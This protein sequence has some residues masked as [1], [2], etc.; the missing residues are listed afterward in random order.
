MISIHRMGVDDVPFLA[1][2][3]TITGVIQ[4]DN[5]IMLFFVVR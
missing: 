1:M 4:H 2:L 3:M 5:S